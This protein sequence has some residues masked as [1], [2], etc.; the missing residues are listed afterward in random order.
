M[1]L[2]RRTTLAL[3]G[4]IILTSLIL[5]YPSSEHEV[6]VDSFFIH[7]LAQAIVTDGY[8]EWILNPFSY[9][10][11]YPLSYPSA[12]PF[13]LASTG[14][15]SGLNLEASILMI[16]LL[17]G[18]IGILCAFMMAR[19]FHSEPLFALIVAFLYGLAP[20]FLAFTLWSASTRSLFMALLP[21]FVWALLASYRKRPWPHFAVLGLSVVILASTHRLAALLS[22]VVLALLVS[23]ILLLLIRILRVHFPRIVLRNSVRRATPHLALASLV[24]IAGVMVVGTDLLSEYTYGE[25]LSGTEPQVQLLNLSV[26]IARSGGVAL[27]L[28]LFGLVAL[29]RQRNKTIRESFLALAFLGLIPTLL[30]R[31]YAGF[32]IL[33]LLVL[34]GGLGFLGLLKFF[35]KRPRMASAMGV[36]LTL[37]VAGFSV[38]VLGVEISRSTQIDSETYA[39]SLYAQFLLGTGTTV[40]NEGLTGIQFAAISGYHVLPVGGAGTTFQSPE[41][42]AFGFYTPDEVTGQLIRVSLQELTIESDSLWIAPNIQA[43]LDWVVI[44]QSPNNDVPRRL[45]SRYEPTFLLELKAASGQ[46]LAYGNSYCSDLGLWAHAAAYRIYENGRENLWWIYSPGAPSSP[47]PPERCS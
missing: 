30:L 3:L 36:A 44:L 23:V 35:R 4:S 40:A 19:E 2:G 26:S 27:P 6:G 18:P 14:S 16:A 15:L 32:Y 9:F 37:A 20:R 1:N 34:L 29:T 17:L 46:F 11:W 7:T 41:L 21:I 33:P 22:V 10:G 42:L 25:L 24:V 8:A 47:G 45:E 28:M 31:Q 5:R 43:E 12:G 38:Y 39:T 13:F